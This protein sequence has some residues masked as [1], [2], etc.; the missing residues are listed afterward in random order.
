MCAIEQFFVKSETSR[1]LRNHAC[2]RVQQIIKKTIEDIWKK[3]EILRETT[4]D[5]F[6]QFYGKL[7]IE[8]YEWNM[9]YYEKLLW[10]HLSNFME[11]WDEKKDEMKELHFYSINCQF[12]LTFTLSS[13]IPVRV[14][15]DL[16]HDY[17]RI[18]DWYLDPIIPISYW[19]RNLLFRNE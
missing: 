5:I 3:H 12:L 14:K 15:Y 9:I 2:F 19:Q 4:L 10:T 1:N 18:I 7:R 11:N 16:C 8:K 13:D 17:W 6:E